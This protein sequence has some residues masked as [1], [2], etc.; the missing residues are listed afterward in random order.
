VLHDNPNAAIKLAPAVQAPSAWQ[1]SAEFERISSRREC[2]Q[3]VAWF[4]NLAQRPGKRLAT[5]A[6]GSGH[7]RTITGE[8]GSAAP[9]APQLGRYDYEP[10][11]LR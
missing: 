1:A 2:R 8:Y 4:G 3:Q 5:V 7:S 9:V 10:D 6:V 11:G